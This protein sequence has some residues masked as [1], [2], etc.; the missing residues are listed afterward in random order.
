M[1]RRVVTPV[2]AAAVLCVTLSGCALGPKPSGHPI[3]GGSPSETCARCHGEIYAEWRASAHAA[4]YT[5]K[6][7]QLATRQHQETDCLRCHIPA[8]LDSLTEQPVRASHL[9]EGV[10]CESC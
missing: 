5:R 6:E 10:N 9:A 1:S 4:A 7:F 3:A 2:V 8:S